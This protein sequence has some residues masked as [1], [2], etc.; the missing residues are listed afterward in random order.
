MRTLRHW[1]R[2]WLGVTARPW[3]AAINKHHARLTSLETRMAGLERV[4]EEEGAAQSIESCKT[5][6]MDAH[7]GAN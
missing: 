4:L 3:E 5:A 7:L 6:D 2:S 1:V